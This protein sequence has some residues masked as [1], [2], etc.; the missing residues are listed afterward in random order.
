MILPRDG[1]VELI[2]IK[3]LHMKWKKLSSLLYTGEEFPSFHF[4]F[5]KATAQIKVNKLVVLNAAF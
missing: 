4:L 3:N 1:L 5:Y 2:D